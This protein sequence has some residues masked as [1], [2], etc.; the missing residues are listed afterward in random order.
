MPVLPLLVLALLTPAPARQE[1]AYSLVHK[2]VVGE[3]LTYDTAVVGDVQGT[4]IKASVVTIKKV[5]AVA[6]DGGYTVEETTIPGPVLI[7]GEETPVE[8]L[9][10]TKVKRVFSPRG[11]LVSDDAEADGANPLSAILGL[12]GVYASETDVK[13]GEGYTAAKPKV[14]QKGA[15]EPLTFRVDRKEGTG[16]AERLILIGK[17]KGPKGES[18]EVT[19]SLALGSFLLTKSVLKI[20]GV[21]LGGATGDFTATTTLRK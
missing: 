9:E 12:A 1:A 17:G 18:V 20:T 8:G 16:D 21:D 19:D 11:V 14:K 4:P 5:T 7:D 2:A 10:E 15:G 3:T 6:P 13:I